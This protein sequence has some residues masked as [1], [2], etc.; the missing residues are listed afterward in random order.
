MKIKFPALFL[1]IIGG[2]FILSC[3]HNESSS[4]SGIEKRQKIQVV[5]FKWRKKL[6]SNIPDIQ[7][8]GFFEKNDRFSPVETAGTAFDT[9]AKRLLVGAAVGGFYCLD[10]TS[11]ETVWRFELQDPVGSIPAYDSQRKR[12]YFGADDGFI[13]ALHSRSGRLLWKTD[14]GSE[15]KRKIWLRN[16]T[17]YTVNADNT[18][19]ALDPEGGEIIWRYRRDPVDG[20]SSVG[21][22]ELTFA[23][24]MIVAGFADGTVACIDEGFGAEQWVVDLSEDVLSKAKIDDVVLIDVD[25]TP[26]VVDGVVVAAS[27]AGGVF[28]LDFETGDTLWSRPEIDKVTGAANYVGEVVLVRSG[29]KGMISLESKTGNT[30]FSKNFGLGL[31]S[32]P[33]VFDDLLLISD[34]EAGLYFVG[35]GTG[36]IVN[37]LDMEGGFFAIPTIHGGQMLIM[38]NWSTLFSFAIN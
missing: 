11:G 26:V 19:F 2:L 21:Y 17:L 18:I 27:S 30:I 22:G 9:D 5:K 3:G 16:D 31:K 37:L 23:N 1:L 7:V 33:V 10:A 29:E 15:L 13:Y 32:D 6:H 35:G 20:F 4:L 28:G 12:V 36:D 34:T 38:G 8:P 14:A 25:A 24:G